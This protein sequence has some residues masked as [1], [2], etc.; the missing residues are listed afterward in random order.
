MPFEVGKSGSFGKVYRPHYPC[1]DSNVKLLDPGILATRLKKNL[2]MVDGVVRSKKHAEDSYLNFLQSSTIGKVFISKDY[3][4]DVSL[5]MYINSIMDDID[6]RFSYHNPS[7]FFCMSEKGAQLIYKHAGISIKLVKE[8]IK[9]RYNHDQDY[10]LGAIVACFELFQ[11]IIIM[12]S[13]NL[14][15]CDLKC[16]NIMTMWHSEDYVPD[17]DHKT[18]SYELVPKFTLIDFGISIHLQYLNDY[19]KLIRDFFEDEMETEFEDSKYYLNIKYPPEKMS[20]DNRM[21][22]FVLNLTHGKMSVWSE[23]CM[24]SKKLPS[25]MC[26]DLCSLIGLLMNPCKTRKWINRLNKLLESEKYGKYFTKIYKEYTKMIT[27][28]DNDKFEK[29]LILSLKYM[30]MYGMMSVVVELSSRFIKEPVWSRDF[31]KITQ[32]YMDDYWGLLQNPVTMFN[33]YLKSFLKV[34]KDFEQTENMKMLIK[35]LRSFLN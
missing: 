33:N 3:A 17:F 31:R 26:N 29:Y 20:D 21:K 9:K 16:D 10:Y 24:D 11:K 30:D 14:F 2:Y 34:M 4:L 7:P 15:H 22:S 13:K 23:K 19:F 5:E 32:T 6:P 12:N 27:F 25:N 1:I 35:T 8:I 28:S 18:E